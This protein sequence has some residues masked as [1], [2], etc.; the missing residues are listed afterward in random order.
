MARR[1][2]EPFNARPAIGVRL[3][4]RSLRAGPALFGRAHPQREPLG[5]GS[6]VPAFAGQFANQ[7]LKDNKKPSGAAGSGGSVATDWSILHLGEID[8]LNQARAVER[9]PTVQPTWNV[10][11]PAFHVATHLRL[12]KSFL[13]ADAA[14][15]RSPRQS[16]WSSVDFSRIK[17]VFQRG[18]S[19]A[20][21]QSRCGRQR[22]FATRSLDSAAA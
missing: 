13:E 8:P 22:G 21:R 12:R 4:P 11:V 3:S 1:R 9:P 10:C 6:P 16:Q 18:L 5:S 20:S 19:G 7:R 17:N 2:S 15:K 14:Y